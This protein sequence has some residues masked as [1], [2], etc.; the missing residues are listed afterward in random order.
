MARE[1]LSKKVLEQF[2]IPV[3]PLAEQHRI[4]ARIDQLMAR[5]DA[6]EKLRT[7][8]EQQRLAVNTAALG[9]LLEAQES[10]TFAHFWQFITRHF[11]ELYTVKENVA[12]LR[13]AILQLAVMGKLVPQDPN[14]L[15]AMKLVKE[16]K[17][18]KQQLVK[19]GKIKK[20]KPLPKIRP[21]EVPYEL[22]EAWEW[23]RLDT[24]TSK[25]TDGDHKT[26]PRIKEGHRLLSAKNVRDGYIDFSNCDFI[27]EQHY[28]KSRERCL[29]E[30][31][32]LLIVSV[33]GTIGRTS[34][35]PEDSDF[36]LVRSVALL[37]PLLINNSYL[38]YTMN[39]ELLQSSIHGRKRGGAQ[40]CLYLSEIR[41]FLFPLPPAI[42]Q[43]RIVT[44]ADKLLTLCDELEKQIDAASH[45]QAGL[46]NAIMAQ[47]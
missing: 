5:C 7:E 31:G 16:I 11:G 13:K 20:T 41:Q 18:E 44:K 34:L 40:P 39:S 2:E 29:P 19:E 47:V 33:G 6:L 27:S 30:T 14:D 3:P 38:R 43:H 45:K 10:D 12:V 35:V 4:V 25:I 24:I 8:H 42:E 28:R 9:Q 46:L 23:V 26:P 32:D 37:K 22:P 21:E 17:T 15:P 36:A 1:G